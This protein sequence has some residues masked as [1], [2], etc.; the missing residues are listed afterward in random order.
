MIEFTEEAVPEKARLFYI[1]VGILG[2]K[3]LM[4]YLRKKG[5]DSA[6]VLQGVW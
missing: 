5:A 3:R 6:L 2:P 1:L 4:V